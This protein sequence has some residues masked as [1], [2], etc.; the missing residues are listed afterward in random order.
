MR[1]Y[2]FF[3]FLT[4]LALI[5]TA[6]TQAS[7]AEAV[8]L[9]FAV[10]PIMDA[11]PM[12]VAQQEGLFEQQGVQVAFISAASAAE[13]DQL[14]IAGQADGMINDPVAT[15]LYNKDTL[16]VQIV[17]YAITATPEYGAF[18][19]LASGQSGITTV[20][21]LQGVQIGISQGTVIEY[22]TDRFLQAEGLDPEA[23][24]T[25]A[26]PKMPDRMSLLGSGELSAALLP[27]PLAFLA[28]Q[29]GAQIILD[30]FSHPEYAYSTIAFRKEIID[31]HPEAI[32]AFLAA[33]EKA[34]QMINADPTRWSS[35]L[36]EQKLVP[37]PIMGS[38]Q[39]PPYPAAGVPSQAQ[40]AD[41][42]ALMQ[43]KGLLAV[44]LPYSDSVNPAFLP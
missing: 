38:Y 5:L 19:I 43:A 36:S 6:C 13:R 37:A 11:L 2:P 39:V 4:I 9:R 42:L 27:D 22:L 40:W 23:I 18:Y 41:V 20:D 21:G 32:R 25:I 8:T 10:L 16:Q 44:D 30:G 7:P 24:E 26:I 14:I 1:R 12:F 35:L 28:A 33:V 3:V 34:T 31:A 17:R 29:Q 15:A